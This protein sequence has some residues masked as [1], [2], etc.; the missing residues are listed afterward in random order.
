MTLF[1][2]RFPWRS[3]KK[4]EIHR[5]IKVMQPKARTPSTI[6]AISE[7][8]RA[9]VGRRT[10]VSFWSD[11]RNLRYESPIMM[12]KSEKSMV[13]LESIYPPLLI[14]IPQQL[15]YDTQNL[16]APEPQHLRK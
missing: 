5:P 12:P 2:E 13:T 3:S 16:N 7:R 11:F 1:P 15:K 10:R 6:Y 8:Y 4:Q 14:C 9:N